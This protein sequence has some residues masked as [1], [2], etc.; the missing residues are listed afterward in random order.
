MPPHSQRRMGSRTI[1]HTLLLLCC[2]LVGYTFRCFNEM[3]GYVI[4]FSK[5]I[6]FRGTVTASTRKIII[7]VLFHYAQIINAICTTLQC[8]GALH[9]FRSITK[10]KDKNYKYISY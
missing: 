2:W 4:V 1:L 9:E 10:I 5:V 6:I 8:N 7:A 3:K